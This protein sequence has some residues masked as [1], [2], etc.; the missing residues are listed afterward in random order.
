ML[1]SDCTDSPVRLL[2]CLGV[3]MSCV[4]KILPA[5]VER[6]TPNAWSRAVQPEHPFEKRD[7]KVRVKPHHLSW[8]G[9]RILALFTTTS[10]LNKGLAVSRPPLA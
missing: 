9:Q 8:T 4:A 1:A 5:S 7:G 10:V 2:S 3:V 6:Q